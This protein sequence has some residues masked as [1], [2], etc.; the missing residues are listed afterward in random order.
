[1]KRWRRFIFLTIYATIYATIIFLLVQ[2]LPSSTLYAS[3]EIEIKGRFDK[4]LFTLKK[5]NGKTQIR[6]QRGFLSSYKNMKKT[7]TRFRKIKIK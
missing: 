6:N 2:A 4:T 3:E 1:M 7:K 5:V